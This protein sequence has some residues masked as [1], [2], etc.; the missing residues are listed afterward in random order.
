MPKL[1]PIITNVTMDNYIPILCK[2]GF[3]RSEEMLHIPPKINVFILSLFGNYCTQKVLAS[4]S[5]NSYFWTYWT[6]VNINLLLNTVTLVY[7]ILITWLLFWCY[8][9]SFV[10]YFCLRWYSFE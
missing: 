5:Q 6:D 8:C 4:F 3:I 10:S 7:C 1:L 2:P 9:A